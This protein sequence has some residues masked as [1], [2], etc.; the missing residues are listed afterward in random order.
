MEDI[1]KAPAEEPA[2]K[3]DN[4]KDEGAAQSNAVADGEEQIDTSASKEESKAPSKS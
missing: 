2:V 4:Q 1:G 3:Q